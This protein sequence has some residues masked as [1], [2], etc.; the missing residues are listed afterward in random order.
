MSVRGDRRVPRGDRAQGPSL[1]TAMGS[2]LSYGLMLTRRVVMIGGKGGVGKTT[3]AA[4]LALECS[5]N[6]E[7]TLVVSTDQTPSLADIFEL[8]NSPHGPHEVTEGLFIWELGFEEIRRMWDRKFGRE[9]Y[10]VFSALVSIEYEEFV[11][12]I[13]SVLPALAEEFMVDHIREM[14]SDG[15]FQRIIWDTAPMGHTLGLLKTPRMLREHLRPAP[16][17]YSRLRLGDRS[18]RSILE[19]IRQ[20]EELSAKDMAFLQDQVS[21]VL[22]LIPEAL[23]VQQVDRILAELAPSR[24]QVGD[25]I[26]NGVV[27]GAESGFLSRRAREQQPYLA[28]IERRYPG[29]RVH[30]V[31]L[32]AE[33]VKGVSRIE[34]VRSALFPR[35]GVQ[36]GI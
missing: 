10:H 4:A 20:W 19:T 29:L 3:C 36:E 33:E 15:G 16:R 28:L 6:G 12:F 13:V 18:R 17:I 2:G 30:R 21:Y 11:E 22:V 31:P 24:L 5:R 25:L 34:R 23:A 1:D 35:G 9:V 7:R 32:F 8:P 26:M 14:A 27:M